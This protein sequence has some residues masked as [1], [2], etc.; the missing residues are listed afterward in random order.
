MAEPLPPANPADTVIFKVFGTVGLVR[1]GRLVALHGGRQRTLLATLLINSG[2]VVTKEQFFAE[3]WDG[4]P[5]A[6]ADNALQA[7]VAR[8][9]KLLK[10]HF[11]EQFAR[12]RLIT[13]PTGYVLYTEPHE[14]DATLFERLVAAAHGEMAADP[15]RA[16]DMFDLAL[17]LWDGPVLEGVTG[18][19]MCHGSVLHLEETRLAAIED[20]FQAS[21]AAGIEL[22]VISE[23]KKMATLYPWRERLAE[24]LMVALYRSG[25]QAD[26]LR[27][28][29]TVRRR[30]VNELGMEPS[31]KL[32]D[33]MQAILNQ[34]PSLE[35]AYSSTLPDPFRARGVTISEHGAISTDMEQ[36]DRPVLY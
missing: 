13:L 30:L 1:D 2:K 23:L 29:D 6:K 9:R 18:G 20:K 10:S 27:E 12:E 3:L 32:K 15:V 11:G 33:R 14:V 7:L 25:R 8:L 16:T 17:R 31:P 4:R 35:L 19:P 22:G 34:D 5:V 26:A 24:L 21:V 36:T 28:Y